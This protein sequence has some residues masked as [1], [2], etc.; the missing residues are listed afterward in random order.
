MLAKVRIARNQAT[1]DPAT[2]DATLEELNREIREALKDLRELARGIHPPVLSDQGLVKA[3]EARVA[4]LPIEVAV[5]ADGDLASVRYAEDVEGA[6]YFFV[7][8]GLANVM[9][10]A[11]ATETTVRL[12]PSNGSLRVEVIDDGQGFDPTRVSRSGLS[13]LE[14][15][16]EAVGG[17]VSVVSRPGDGTRLI[18]FLP[19][20]RTSPV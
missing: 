3:I 8:E 9:K 5:E 17:T 12:S 1:R 13:G 16:I 7:C 4:H 14:D 19:A 18:A 11:A 10:H 2:V 15:R 6:A 20:G